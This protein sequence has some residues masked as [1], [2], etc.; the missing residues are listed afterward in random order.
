MAGKSGICNL[1]GMHGRTKGGRA[2]ACPP[3][4]DSPASLDAR[5]RAF[6]VNLEAR[7]YSASGVESHRWA[8]K[9]F[10][11]W[12]DSRGLCRPEPFTRPLLEEYQL[13]LFHY[14]SP[15][16]NQPLA[17]NSQLARLG[18]IQRFFAWLCR[19]GVLMANPAA[20]LDL[21]RKQA[22]ALPKSLSEPEITRLLA[23]PELT[24]PF[25]LRDRVILELFYATGIRRA[26]MANLD[27]GDFDPTLQ[28]LHI[29]RGKGGKDRVLPVGAR[30]AEWLERYLAATRPLFAHHP[31]ETALFLSGYGTRLT[32]AFLGTWVSRLMKQA[33]VS[34]PGSCHL[35][36]HSCAT[37]MLEGGADI[38]YI[39]AMLGHARLDTTQIY[40][41]V[42]IR[43]L[44]EVHARSHP[45]GRTSQSCP[46]ADQ[47]DHTPPPCREP[48]AP[49]HPA[50][51]ALPVP[52]PMNAVL[53]PPSQAAAHGIGHTQGAKPPGEDEPPTAEAV[54]TTTPPPNRPGG[55]SSTLKNGSNGAPRGLQTGQL[56][57]YGYRWMDPQTGRW[58]SR[59][60]IGERG[61]VNLYGF[62]T[63]NGI[64]KW[65]FLGNEPNGPVLDANGR[66]RFG[67]GQADGRAGQF[68]PRP[69]TFLEPI[70]TVHVTP[71]RFGSG[72]GSAFDLIAEIE[73]FRIYL[74]EVQLMVDA[75]AIAHALPEVCRRQR[76]SD[77]S[78]MREGC[79]CCIITMHYKLSE[80]GGEF[81]GVFYGPSGDPIA[82][83]L[84]HAIYVPKRCDEAVVERDYP[85]FMK[86][87][88][89]D[90]ENRSKF[91]M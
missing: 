37:H 36:R 79:G 7:A 10:L 77:W 39:Q 66:W 34:K 6:L 76:Y 29:R 31:A 20:D 90:V 75:V 19:S 55:G 47:A 84:A 89:T 54:P 9:Q 11:A 81:R 83:L 59:D 57:H 87:P 25:G 35:F 22:R 17:T 13:F 72:V 4:P 86:N 85:R 67:R 12:A 80:R 8:F 53:T 28:T 45:H 40:T 43:A 5:V 16:T 18:C 3:P 88:W 46:L 62:A 63:N 73:A 48:L 23:L 91:P 14:R 42:S 41:H 2:P 71:S 65:D 50:S 52:V 64:S 26:E 56:T 51:D 58:P 74:N 27:T 38:R 49:S 69:T 33:D 70:N 24:S 21:P 30:A 1:G 68:M 61:G 44:Q 32:K 15:R 78:P 60:P 82:I